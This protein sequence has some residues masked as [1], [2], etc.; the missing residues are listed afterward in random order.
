[1]KINNS[2]IFSLAL[3]VVMVV[4]CGTFDAAAEKQHI[5][6]KVENAS[7]YYSR[8]PFFEK[9][10]EFVRT[11]D[12]NRLAI[13]RYEIAGADCYAFVQEA[14]LKTV[15]DIGRYEAHR[16]Y[17]D[18]QMPLDGNEVFGL[19]DTPDEVIANAPWAKKDIVFFNAPM[20][21]VTVKPGEFA[22]FF[23]SKGGH[24]PGLT[25]GAPCKIRKLVIKVR[26]VK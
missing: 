19:A 8:N 13:G 11:H 23:P 24:A 18:I 5:V 25:E 26:D 4:G 3:A 20:N 2:M 14:S 12:L 9:A 1:M 21:K 6:D 10:F 17:I 15:A 7:R 16:K 22:M